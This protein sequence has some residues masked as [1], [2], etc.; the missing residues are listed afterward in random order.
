MLGQARTPEDLE[1]Y[2]FT[3]APR[4]WEYTGNGRIE[5]AAEPTAAAGRR[6][7]TAGPGMALLRAAAALAPEDHHFISIGLGVGS[8]TSQDWSKGGLHYARVMDLAREVKD[9]VTFAAAV[10]MLGITDRHMP[11]AAQPGFADRVTQIAADVRADLGLPDLPILHTDYEVE[12]TGEL[13]ADS[14]VGMRFRPLILTLPERIERCAIVPTDDLG[15]QDDHHFD[16]A[17]QKDWSDRAMQILV[18]RAWAPWPR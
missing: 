16:M 5:A 4:L 6:R 13:A 18:D 15:M 11:E 9:R 10:V 8:S 12:S 17:G 1:P 3:T 14:V 7:S 2:F